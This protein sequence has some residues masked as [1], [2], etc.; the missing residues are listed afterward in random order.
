MKCRRHL[1]PLDMDVGITAGVF[2]KPD[3]EAIDN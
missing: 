2:D 3:L 1:I